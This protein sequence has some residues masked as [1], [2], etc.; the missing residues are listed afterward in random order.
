MERDIRDELIGVL[1]TDEDFRKS[2]GE[3]ENKDSVFINKN[4]DIQFSV[5]S[6]SKNASEEFYTGYINTIEGF[7][8][9]KL[10]V[11]YSGFQSPDLRKAHFREEINKYLFIFQESS[12]DKYNKI[13]KSYL[14]PKPS[15]VTYEDKFYSVPVFS[16]KESVVEWENKY[17]YNSRSLQ[18]EY[19]SFEEF[20]E[21]VKEGKT[22]GRIW[23]YGE[24][25]N[26][27]FIVWRDDDASLF[28]LGPITGIQN[29]IDGQIIK[30]NN[31]LYKLNI[32]DYDDYSVYSEKANP[33]ILHIVEKP[34]LTMCQE[35]DTL[36]D[37][38]PVLIKPEG[39][40]GITESI[41][42]D[43]INIDINKKDDETLLNTFLQSC[44]NDNLY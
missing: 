39:Q 29:G 44:E 14:T 31:E 24:R 40:D 15:A 11:N 19:S 28:A 10:D 41:E 43:S 21:R 4:D 5:K 1:A 17:Q 25:N 34:Y 12:N 38:E 42:D 36:S 27:K 30:Y 8:D 18:R 9:Y 35:F 3:N 2:M 23:N 32:S 6:M 20:I 37:T 33:S 7:A 26:P 13:W 16:S 22:V